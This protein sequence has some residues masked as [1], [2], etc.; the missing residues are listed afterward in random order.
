MPKAVKG[1]EEEQARI[2]RTAEARA[3]A[4]IGF[5][6]HL[7]VYSLVNILLITIN[8]TTS[9]QYYWFKWPLLGW[10]IGLAMH[11]LGVFVFT[12]G[13]GLKERMVQRELEKMKKPRNR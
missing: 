2:Y 9:P 8:L 5:L 6:I 3:A 1:N 11:G 4:K 13:G 10:G 12:G 7:A